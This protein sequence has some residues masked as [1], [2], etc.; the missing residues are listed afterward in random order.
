MMDIRIASCNLHAR[1]RLPGSGPING[2]LGALAGEPTHPFAYARLE[3][4]L[5]GRRKPV[6]AEKHFAANM[7][8]EM[9][10]LLL[11]LISGPVGHHLVELHVLG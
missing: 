11:R 1:H 4:F 3:K 8:G 10:I 2:V 7:H 5:Q 6:T 9:L